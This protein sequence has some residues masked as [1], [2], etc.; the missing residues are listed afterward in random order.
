MTTIDDV[1]GIVEILKKTKEDDLVIIGGGPTGLYAALL[2]TKNFPNSKIVLIEARP[3]ATRTIIMWIDNK[4]L[5][6][7]PPEILEK[8]NNADNECISN[9]PFPIPCLNTKQAYKNDDTYKYTEDKK[10]TRIRLDLLETEVRLWLIKKGVQIIYCKTPLTKEQLLEAKA[11]TI[12]LADGVASSTSKTIFPTKHKIKISYAA[13]ITF[14]CTVT[15]K[16]AKDQ[17]YVNEIIGKGKNIHSQEAALAYFTKS[18]NNTPSSAYI[19]LQITKESCDKLTGIKDASVFLST[20]KSLP[21][22]ALFSYIEKAF[23]KDIKLLYFSV[24]PIMIQTS[25]HFYENING[26]HLFLMGDAAF[27]THFFSGLGMNRGM[28]AAKEW[29]RIRQEGINYDSFGATQETYNLFQKEKRESLWREIIPSLLFKVSDAYKDCK[30]DIQCLYNKSRDKNDLRDIYTKKVTDMISSNGFDKEV[31]SET[32]LIERK[33]LKYKHKYLQLKRALIGGGE[34]IYI[35]FINTFDEMGKLKDTKAKEIFD[36]KD[37]RSSNFV[38]YLDVLLNN[39]DISSIRIKLSELEL[40]AK[41]SDDE[42]E[43]WLKEKVNKDKMSTWLKRARLD[44]EICC[45]G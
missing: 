18:I 31:A 42:I 23:Y 43:I 44:W 11:K 32:H 26:K 20:L 29:N 37:E 38:K 35:K 25:T 21:E 19:G 30:G 13:V 7:I 40:L 12:L 15:E 28:D 33:Y 45:W 16:A 14:T 9:S 4:F 5:D 17:E 6:A 24:F 41:M 3:I 27:S 36:A 1:S 8:I 34:N 39:K 2:S 10:E 22:G